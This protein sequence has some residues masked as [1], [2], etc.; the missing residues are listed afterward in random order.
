MPC[1]SRVSAW[2]CCACCAGD[3]KHVTNVCSVSMLRST[4]GCSDLLLANQALFCRD[5][6]GG[7][8]EAS[9]WRPQ[10]SFQGLATLHLQAS[11]P[12]MERAEG[13]SK[14]AVH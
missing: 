12:L 14:A 10:V 3:I 2:T 5:R 1:W 6:M 11:A 13:A 9:R 7:S 4:N 8:E